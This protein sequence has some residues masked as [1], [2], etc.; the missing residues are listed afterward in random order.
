M[1]KASS[2]F[3]ARTVTHTSP[4]RAETGV[5]RFQR[6]CCT[7]RLMVLLFPLPLLHGVRTGEGGVARSQERWN[8]SR[9]DRTG[10]VRAK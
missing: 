5:Q 8:P 9:N 7:A 1:I 2:C 3:D 4:L 10:T 6:L